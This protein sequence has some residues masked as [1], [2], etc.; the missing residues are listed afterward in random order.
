MKKAQMRDQLKDRL[1]ALTVEQRRDKS[2]RACQRL[3][4]TSDFQGASTVML[5]LSLPDE[6]DTASAVDAAWHAG[7][8]VVVPKIVWRD[9][10]MEAVMVASW[11]E[12]FNVSPSGLR[13]P[14]QTRTVAADTIDLVVTPGLGFDEQG[15]RLGRG[16]AFY[17]RFFQREDLHAT[18]CGFAFEEQILAAVPTVPHDQSVDCVITDER[19]IRPG[20]QVQ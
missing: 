8:I 17:D 1:Q 9:R 15:Q 12:D 5:F 20:P 14:A 10:H 7:K 2:D 3:V 11:Q 6:I 19:V 13:C 4:A 16:G 18:R